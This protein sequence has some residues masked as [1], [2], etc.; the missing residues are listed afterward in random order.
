MVTRLGGPIV[1]AGR[2]TEAESIGE[3]M[4][5]VRKQR[6]T[7]GPQT[8]R[9]FDGYEHQG[10]QQRDQQDPAGGFSPVEVRVRMRVWVKMGA[11]LT[12][13]V[14]RFAW[15]RSTDLRRA[16]S[17]LTRVG[18][19]SPTQAWTPA[20]PCSLE[21]IMWPVVVLWGRSPDLRRAFSPPS[22]FLTSDSTA[23]SS[24]PASAHLPV[25]TGIGSDLNDRGLCRYVR[26]R[27][28]VPAAGALE[29]FW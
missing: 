20:L 9:R 11:H 24:L 8:R 2:E 16:L 17:P 23:S 1:T 12:F 5:G 26:L 29:R 15:G 10:D 13:I 7:V 21:A 25:P 6:Q 18:L 28:S 4:S 22:Y 14:T 19:G 3:I 27:V